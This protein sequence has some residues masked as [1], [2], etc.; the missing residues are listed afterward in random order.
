MTD[1]LYH[2]RPKSYLRTLIQNPCIVGLSS[3]NRPVITFP[4]HNSSLLEIQSLSGARRSAAKSMVFF[5]RK[6]KSVGMLGA[7]KV[8]SSQE[9]I[10]IYFIRSLKVLSVEHTLTAQHIG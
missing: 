5:N 4:F 2:F 6:D 3:S 1:V 10:I 7:V 8:L 9:Y